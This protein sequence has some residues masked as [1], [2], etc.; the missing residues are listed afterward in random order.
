MESPLRGIPFVSVQRSLR[1]LG[2]RRE[3]DLHPDTRLVDSC[4]ATVCPDVFRLCCR[5]QE[6][7][8][9]CPDAVGLIVITVARWVLRRKCSRGTAFG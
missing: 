2:C 9:I 1:T 4:A 7:P 3:S 6:S 8:L 5:V